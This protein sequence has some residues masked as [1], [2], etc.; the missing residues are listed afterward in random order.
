VAEKMAALSVVH[1]R[2][3][4][5]GL[6]DLCLE[7]HSRAA[8]KKVFLEELARTLN[9]GRAAPERGRTDGRLGWPGVSFGSAGGAACDHL[10]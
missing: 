9:A 4:K 7:I 10:A 8:N 5:V 1:D 2:L 6:G 3:Q